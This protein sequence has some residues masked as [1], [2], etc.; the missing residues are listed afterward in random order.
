MTPSDQLLHTSFLA[1]DAKGGVILSIYVCG[2]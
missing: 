2:Q 1:L